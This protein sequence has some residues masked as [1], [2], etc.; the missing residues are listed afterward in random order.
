MNRLRSIIVGVLCVACVVVHAQ[1]GLTGKWQGTTASGRPVVLDAKVRGQ[2]LTGRIT[3]GQQS[4]AMTDGK[5][6][7]NTFSFKAT[8]EERTATFSGRLVGDHVELTVQGVSSPLT[9]KRV[10]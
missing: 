7:Q 8:M 2:Q 9:L 6:E 4:A 3:V 5:V 1:S 10:T